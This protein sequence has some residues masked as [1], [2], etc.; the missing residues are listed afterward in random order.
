MEHNASH[1]QDWILP[2]SEK[3]GAG[4]EGVEKAETFIEVETVF[5]YYTSS[6]F[7]AHWRN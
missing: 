6:T 1:D 2:H 3:F 4:V 5:D 7:V